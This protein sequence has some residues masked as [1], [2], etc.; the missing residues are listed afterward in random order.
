M[1]NIDLSIIIVNYNS[2]TLLLE[3]FQSLLRN[4]DRYSFELIVVDNGSR[5]EE[6]INLKNLKQ[7][8]NVF[9]IL[10]KDN[11]GY[12]K[13]V[14]IGLELS[15][16]NY[17]LISNPDVLYLK[18]SIKELITAID[19]VSNCGAVSPR[20][21]W[22]EKQTFL[23]PNNEL[24]TPGY[25]FIKSLASHNVYL[26]KYILR[27]WL[28]KTLLYWKAEKYLEVELISGSCIMTRKNIVNMVGNFD[29]QFPLYFEDTDWFLRVKKAGYTLYYVPEANVV[30]FYNQSAKQEKES[31]NLKF[32]LSMKKFLRKHF[33][34]QMYLFD[35]LNKVLDYKSVSVKSFS[36]K[37]LGF[38]KEPIFFTIKHNS[39]KLLLLS[40]NECMMP[41]AASF[42]K[43]D[44][45]VMNKYL[46][47]RLSYGRYFIKIFDL[48]G[49]K[50]L[51]SFSFY[52]EI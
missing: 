42:L 22:D 6:I 48:N 20:V 40:P 38:L 14:N 1:G 19:S 16:G 27:E 26:E 34:K 24:I 18:N 33:K 35:P 3:C 44:Y 32:N 25:I 28:K 5:K 37:E 30:H 10:N 29:E 49:N 12:A 39:A 46:W 50:E 21:W 43:S 47:D 23:L 41:A 11:I 15:K 45:F 7:Y 36:F 17:I 8:D 52:K 4:M 31:S 13:A 2:T 51:E 9:L